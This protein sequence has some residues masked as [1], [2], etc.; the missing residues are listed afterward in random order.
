M[1]I[2]EVAGGGVCLAGA[3]ER[4]V[5]SLQ[6]MVEVLEQGTLLRATGG[7]FAMDGGVR[8]WRGLP[9]SDGRGRSVPHLAVDARQLPSNGVLHGAAAALRMCMRPEW[10]P[11]RPASP[12]LTHTPPPRPL[13][14]AAAT[15][16][17]KQSS[18]SHAIFTITLEQRKLVLPA[19][20]GAG[21]SG[22]GG[23]GRADRR[24][25][26]GEDSGDEEEDEGEE[27]EGA[28]DSYLCAKMHLVDLAG[29]N[30]DVCVCVSG[31]G[32]GGGGEV[33]W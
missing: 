4:E 7:C 24:A 22:G 1:T 10:V 27:G 14:P 32:G 31:G 12:P 6:E 18:R 17:N 5:G 28:D 20:A 33:R 13:T 3:T 11:R 23:S 16:M 26:A 29:A 8:R 19:G 25:G 9:T 2:R 30:A 21:G 15:G